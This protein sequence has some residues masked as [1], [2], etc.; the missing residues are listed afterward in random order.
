MSFNRSSMRLHLLVLIAIAFL[1]QT[2]SAAEELVF[3]CKRTEKDFTE[4]YEMK[5]VPASKS[6]KAKIFLDGRDLDQSDSNGTQVVKSIQLFPPQIVILIDARFEPE[7]LNGVS[8]S[9]GTVSTLLTLNQ[10]TGKLK[11]VE[12]IRGGILGSN[13]GDGT[14]ISEET[15]L[16]NKAHLE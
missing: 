16:P 13:L 5:L 6:S 1:H 7:S 4:E 9:A 15:C 3:E 10:S 11:K 2:A 14:R 12:T 8:Y